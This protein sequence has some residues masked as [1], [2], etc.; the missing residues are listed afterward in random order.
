M[1]KDWENLNIIA[2]IFLRLASIRLT[3]TLKGLTS[4]ELICKQ[5]TIEPEMFTLKP[6]NKM[7]GLKT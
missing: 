2:L 4:C 1:A 7:P 3:K 6:I 5:W